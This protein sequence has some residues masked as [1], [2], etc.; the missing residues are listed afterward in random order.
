M[1]SIIPNTSQGNVLANHHDHVPYSICMGPTP[2]IHCRHKLTKLRRTTPMWQGP[3]VKKGVV[4]LI[5]MT[6]NFSF[7]RFLSS[8]LQLLF[9]HDHLLSPQTMG[10]ISEMYGPHVSGGR[11][12]GEM[13]FQRRGGAGVRRRNDN[14]FN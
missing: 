5:L 7:V 4:Q 3:P 14:L 10:T 13:P 12:A 9:V 8:Q 6:K 1:A 2:E 11:E